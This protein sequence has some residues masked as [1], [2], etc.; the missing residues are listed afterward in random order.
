MP[1]FNH[2]S[3][4]PG[5]IA[6]RTVPILPLFQE[7]SKTSLQSQNRS[8]NL[9]TSMCSPL[10]RSIVLYMKNNDILKVRFY[11]LIVLNGIQVI[12]D[13]TNGTGLRASAVLNAPHD[14]D[15]IS[16]KT[17]QMLNRIHIVHCL[18]TC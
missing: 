18:T 13:I 3:L 8:H 16:D 15:I 11:L 1:E 17:A 7:I 2:V 14:P 6:H 12:G 9:S 5:L 4:T 10:K